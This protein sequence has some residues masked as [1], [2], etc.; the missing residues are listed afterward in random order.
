MMLEGGLEEEVRRLYAE[1]YLPDGSTAAQAIGYKEFLSY[2]RGEMTL[3]EAAD[4]LRTA[5]RRYAKRQLTWFRRNPAMH[6]LYPDETAAEAAKQGGDLPSLLCQ[7]TV[8]C[9]LSD[10]NNAKE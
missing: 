8:A 5:T 2:L 1:G 6:W 9:Y 4:N 3:D 7:K 10:P